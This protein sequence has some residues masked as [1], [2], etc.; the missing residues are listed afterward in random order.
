M[1]KSREPRPV[2]SPRSIRHCSFFTPSD[3]LQSQLWSCG[4]ICMFLDQSYLSQDRLKEQQ[5]NRQMYDRAWDEPCLQPCCDFRIHLWL[6]VYWYLNPQFSSN[7]YLSITGIPFYVKK[8]PKCWL[9]PGSPES[10]FSS[11]AHSSNPAIHPI[12][13]PL[14]LTTFA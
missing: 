12:G 6:V 4:S 8:A 9:P 1:S 11:M 14:P 13:A 3:W 5:V 10:A 2:C 7:T